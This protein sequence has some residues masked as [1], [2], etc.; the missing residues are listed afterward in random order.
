MTTVLIRLAIAI[1]LV[2]GAWLSWSEARIVARV[3]DARER[4]A[5]FQFD[6][7]QALEISRS[8]SDYLP[9]DAGAISHDVQRIRATA[10]YWLGN[11]GTVLENLN[12]ASRDDAADT[13]D[14]DVL[15]TSANAAFRASE[16]EGSA[17]PARV[18]RLDGVLQAY[19]GVLKASPRH[20]DAAYNY[21]Y[22]SRLRDRIASRAQSKTAAA[23]PAP[24]PKTAGDLPAGP[25]IHGRP[26]MFPPEMKTE[27]MQIIAPMEYGDREAQPEATPGG[28]IQRKGD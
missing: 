26:G 9:G 28:R 3:A 5:T 16:R 12:P 13:I 11:Y 19:A 17:G 6:Q 4:M 7:P 20:A 21:E 24:A 1:V 18:Q 27:D 2:I 8:M 25:T 23:T 15:F 22:V 10:A 14:P